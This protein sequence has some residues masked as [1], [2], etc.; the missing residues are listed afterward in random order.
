MKPTDLI[1][2]LPGHPIHPPLTG[3]AIGAYTLATA[4][5]SLK[6][7]GVLAVSGAHAWWIALVVGLVFGLLAALTGLVDWLSITRGT[8]L[9][10]TATAHMA[11]MLAATGF[12]VAATV[13]GHAGYTH[14]D[15]ATGPFALTVI[16]FAVLSLGG[17]L[18]GAIVYVYGM[19]V[20][21]LP[22]E[23]AARAASPLPHPETEAAE[24]G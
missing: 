6:V 18:G 3:A 12:F 19:R 14:G 4:A 11:A 20:L 24:G 13:W 21:S 15:V 5:A 2:G 10:R 7:A 9:W 1:R 22:K 17:W 8:P 23:P 16:G